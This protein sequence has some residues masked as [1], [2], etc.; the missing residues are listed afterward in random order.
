M[1]TNPK[2]D[3]FAFDL[4]TTLESIVSLR[5]QIPE[6]ALTAA[7]LGTERAGHG[8]VIDEKGLVLTIG[9]L[10]TEAETVWLLDHRENAV[11]A[12]LLGYDQETG[13]GLVQALQPLGLPA[14]QLGSSD[15]LEIADTVVLAGAGG[16]SDAITARIAGKR[17]FAGYW[18]YLLDEA[19]FTVPQHPNWGGT[20][21]IDQQGHLCGIGSLALQTVTSSGDKHGANMI[22]PIDLLPPI[23]DDLQLYG[24]QNKPARPWLGWL[25]QETL[26]GLTIAGVYDEGPADRA[27]VATGDIVVEIDGEP[28]DSLAQLF[29]NV[30]ALGSAGIEVPV[31]VQR[32][33]EVLD[34]AIYSID[35]NDQLKSASVH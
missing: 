6:D 26:D 30:W 35:R 16:L 5:V 33:D 8:V 34:L 21:L 11:P 24:R 10:V 17:E 15:K 25:V 20:A 1:A 28:V 7:V 22:V 32:G 2:P 19:I 29:R 31:S 13:F 18:E 14:M 9:Y 3:D 4:E 27:G 12:H 23:L